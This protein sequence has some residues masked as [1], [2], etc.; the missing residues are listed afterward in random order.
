MVHTLAWRPGVWQLE[1]R[2]WKKIFQREERKQ[3]ARIK[4]LVPVCKT[5]LSS[6]NQRH[7]LSISCQR[8]VDLKGREWRILIHVGL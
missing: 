2:A 4:R 3:I 1:S 8:E 7:F 5:S 6:Q